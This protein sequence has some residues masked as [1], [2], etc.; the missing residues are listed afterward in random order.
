MADNS[1]IF[2]AIEVQTDPAKLRA[3]MANARR[4]SVVDV[5]AAA[6]RR[7]TDIA[8]EEEPGTV[9]YDFWKG[10]AAVEQTLLEERGKAVRATRTRQM[11]RKHG[12]IGTLGKLVTAKADDDGFDQIMARDL[13]ELTG[14]AVVIKHSSAF[15]PEIIAAARARLA[16]AGVDPGALPQG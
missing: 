16:R 4:K 10:I 5:Y 8:P 7:L 3:L 15:E 14:E 13:P 1:R 2:A 9:E 6:F 11:V 12:V